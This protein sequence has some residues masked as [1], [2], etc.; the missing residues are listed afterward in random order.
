M[1]AV[2]QI[3]GKQ[4]TVSPGDTIEVARLEGNVGD[5]LTFKDVFLVTEE[6][7]TTVGNP[8]IPGVVAKA[9]IVAQGKGEKIHVRRFKS[10][11]RYRKQ[12]GFRPQ[13]TTLTILSIGK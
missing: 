10:K 1:F 3:S 2:V 4:F 12:T 5:T 8:S 9:K 11:V 6:G 13:I 7:K